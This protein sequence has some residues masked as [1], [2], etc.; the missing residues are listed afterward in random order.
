MY[1]LIDHLFIIAATIKNM[2]SYDHLFLTMCHVDINPYLK[3]N[4][5]L[6]FLSVFIASCSVA[7]GQNCQCPQCSRVKDSV[8]QCRCCF[9]HLQGKRSEQ[10][11]AKYTGSLEAQHSIYGD[12]H[13]PKRKTQTVI[14]PWLTRLSHYLPD[15]SE[16]EIDLKLRPDVFLKTYEVPNEIENKVLSKNLIPAEDQ[17]KLLD[18]AYLEPLDEVYV[19]QDNESK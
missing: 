13:P 15:D 18:G 11:R 3:Q 16:S 10:A 6:Y 7:G 9:Y 5:L 1:C 17:I 2:A 14:W 19:F 12:T 4:V 8:L